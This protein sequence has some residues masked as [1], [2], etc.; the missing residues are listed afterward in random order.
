MWVEVAK[1][2][3]K[4][5]FFSDR[6]DQL[7]ADRLKSM[8]AS[9]DPR[10][11]KAPVIAGFR[12]GQAGPAHKTGEYLPPLGFVRGLDFDGHF[13]WADIESIEGT[14]RIED[15][16]L[17]GFHQRSIGAWLKLPE[18]DGSPPYLRHLALLAGEPPGIPNLTPL[19]EYYSVQ[20]GETLGR[21]LANM[22]FVTYNL[23][24]DQSVDDRTEEDEM[25]QE[26]MDALAR[27]I[28]SQV[29]AAVERVAPKP[30]ALEQVETKP[31]ETER[32]ISAME[33]AIQRAVAPLQER[34]ERVEAEKGEQEIRF[35]LDRLQQ[36]GRLSP[37]QRTAEEEV[38]RLLPN[39]EARLA[40]V[41]RLAEVSP[42]SA[43]RLASETTRVVLDSGTNVDLNMRAFSAPGGPPQVDAQGER[44][45]RLIAEAKRRAAESPNDPQAFQRALLSLAGE[46]GVN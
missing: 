22:P 4:D 43:N 18:L 39:H 21:V 45:L 8:A 7:T 27:A 37:A 11:R 38:L 24:R 2:E 33:S 31:T 1:V 28:G 25:T 26:Q 5:S 34:L 14:S 16:V 30:V 3:G 12:D 10:F 20:A 6:E 15:A 36:T 17:D 13:L 19:D 9:Y 40:R 46:S 23:D 29:A 35:N 41:K 32:V 42:L 44:D